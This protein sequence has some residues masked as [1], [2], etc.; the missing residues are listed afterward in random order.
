MN[1]IL[2]DAEE[3]MKKALEGTRRELSGLRTGKA[4]PALLDIVKVEAYGQ[5]MSLKE[6]GQVSAPEPRLLVVQPYDK[7]MVK[8]VSRGIAMAELGLNPTDDGTVVR[9]PIPALTEERRKDMVKLVAKYTEEGRVHVRQVRH[10]VNKDVKHQQD[11]GTLAEDDGKRLIADVQ[12]LT[13]K[14]IALLDELL[15][16]KTAEV[17]E[18]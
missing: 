10:D 14:Y 15:K 12:K 16:K 9:I 8:A 1:R 6:L 17:M 5:M 3:R 11:A 13:D 18:V 4:S 2:V 7:A